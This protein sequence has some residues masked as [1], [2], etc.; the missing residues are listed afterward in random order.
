MILKHREGSVS[1]GI[2]IR[3]GTYQKNCFAFPLLNRGIRL[4][5]RKY[6]KQQKRKYQ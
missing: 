3:M 4:C 5:L 6:W 1:A 2:V